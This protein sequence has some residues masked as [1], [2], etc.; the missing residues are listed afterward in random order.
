[1]DN[2]NLKKVC[3]L[4]RKKDIVE[5]LAKELSTSHFIRSTLSALKINKVQIC[6]IKDVQTTEERCQ[7]E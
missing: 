5:N 6:I 7:L 3:I 1:L 2:L 4:E